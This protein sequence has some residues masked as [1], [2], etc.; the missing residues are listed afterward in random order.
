MGISMDEKIKEIEEGK[1]ESFWESEY[2]EDDFVFIYIKKDNK[3]I[4]QSYYYDVE[5][6]LKPLHIN[7]NKEVVML[8]DSVMELLDLCNFRINYNK[9]VYDGFINHAIF[10]DAAIIMNDEKENIIIF[11]AKYLYNKIKEKKIKLNFNKIQDLEIINKNDYNYNFIL[12]LDDYKQEVLVSLKDE[13]KILKTLPTLKTKDIE[14]LKYMFNRD[15]IPIDIYPIYFKNEALF[16]I[17]DNDYLFDEFIPNISRQENNFIVYLKDLI[18]INEHFKEIMKILFFFNYFDEKT[19]YLQENTKASDF[20]AKFFLERYQKG[21]F[22]FISDEID[23]L[24]KIINTDKLHSHISKIIIPTEKYNETIFGNNVKIINEEI[25]L[26]LFDNNILKNIRNEILKIGEGEKESEKNKQ[27]KR[28]V[29]VSE[30]IK[31]HDILV[32]KNKGFSVEDQVHKLITTI[33]NFRN[34]YSHD[35]GCYYG[36]YKKNYDKIDLGTNYYRLN[37]NPKDND[38]NH[39]SKQLVRNLTMFLELYIELIKCY[40]SKY[41][42]NLT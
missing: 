25:F 38:Y 18:Y 6:N 17:K 1:D 24:E 23:K 27:Q 15:D 7:I 11:N 35:L 10:P 28:K 13:G 26:L 22:D 42:L 19:C 40:D 12:G 5:E 20:N 33:I 32:P 41:I 31:I 34:M 16:L 9:Y 30:F 29:S 37:K 4:K 2:F 14:Y 36:S 39:M 3:I 21:I 8:N